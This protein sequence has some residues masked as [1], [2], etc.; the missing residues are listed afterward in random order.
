MLIFL[1]SNIFYAIIESIP[2]I[3]LLRLLKDH[4]LIR[5]VDLTDILVGGVVLWNSVLVFP[6]IFA[7]FFGKIN[8]SIY[9]QLYLCISVFLVLSALMYFIKKISSLK[10]K[11]TIIKFKTNGFSLVMLISILFLY[12]IFIT[13]LSVTF[14]SYDAVAY[15]LPYSIG[16]IKY[17]GIPV[18]FTNAL[19]YLG[20]A[21][22]DPPA[23]SILY[24]FPLFFN[25]NL[26]C[27]KL[28]PINFLVIEIFSIYGISKIIFNKK[29]V[30]LWSACASVAI[31]PINY[32][33]LLTTPYNLDLGLVAYQTAGI[34]FAM[35]LLYS[36]NRLWSILVGI[37]ISLTILTRDISFVFAIPIFFLIIQILNKFRKPLSILTLVP[38]WYI[39]YQ[40][41]DLLVNSHY[42]QFYE[43]LATSVYVFT[44]TFFIVIAVRILDNVNWDGELHLLELTATLLPSIL[45][46]FRNGLIFGQPFFPVT[47][48]GAS[49]DFYEKFYWAGQI[50]LRLWGGKL[51]P[52]YRSFIDVIISLPCLFLSPMFAFVFI[53]FIV[54]VIKT[55]P[56]RFSLNKPNEKFHL[57]FICYVLMS[58]IIWTLLTRG[59]LL[60]LRHSL[61]LIPIMSILVTRGFKSIFK[62][63]SLNS[64]NT[65]IFIFAC[66]SFVIQRFFYDPIMENMP[67]I[68]VYFSQFSTNPD[69]KLI[70]ASIMCLFI[71]Y[72]YRNKII[73]CLGV[74]SVGVMLVYS[75]ILPANA[76]FV[77]INNIG[78]DNYYSEMNNIGDSSIEVMKYY[79]VHELEGVTLTFYAFWLAYGVGEPVIRGDLRSGLMLLKPYLYAEDREWVYFSLKE[80]HV[81]YVLL[82]NQN[83]KNYKN[84]FL[85][86]NSTLLSVVTDN[87]YFLLIRHFGTYDLFAIKE[88][89]IIREPKAIQVNLK[90]VNETG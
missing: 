71:L 26:E 39:F 52:E 72:A 6:M 7:M 36:K 85:L 89:N 61:I 79:K 54:G 18:D 1:L 35:K 11:S 46:L 76:V 16:I 88:Q 62:Y 41:L 2:G 69:W 43:R 56:T 51:I 5:D 12:Y 45:W 75:I 74:I 84:F 80:M 66:T 48:A 60:L 86:K 8:I 87:K 78:W 13:S 44:F 67:Y 22:W 9:F 65:Y 32:F 63:M 40:T 14:R 47:V 38:F 49:S 77:E 10:E 82:P 27:F 17:G 81:K 58:L 83:H 50:S 15:Y 68:K 64:G 37:S 55:I 53:I 34:Y 31:I 29:N 4:H 25:P 59:N 30:A 20:E 28:I 90:I 57:L 73:R 3:C 70:I 33:C 23:I 21:A 24:A 19:F 42:P